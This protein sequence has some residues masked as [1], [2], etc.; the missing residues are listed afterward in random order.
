MNDLNRNNG[1]ATRE[2]IAALGP[3][4]FLDVS[5][6]EFK[7]MTDAYLGALT[8]AGLGRLRAAAQRQSDARKAQA[9]AEAEAAAAPRAELGASE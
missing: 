4:D 7:D 3:F 2:Q 6:A 8:L 1:F 5:Q 9:K